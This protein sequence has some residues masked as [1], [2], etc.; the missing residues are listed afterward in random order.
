MAAWATFP[1]RA[2]YAVKGATAIRA[3]TGSH[4]FI[5]SRKRIGT[6]TEQREGFVLRK[7]AALISLTLALSLRCD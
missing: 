3:G 5:A 2:A 4:A 7:V 1:V 6:S